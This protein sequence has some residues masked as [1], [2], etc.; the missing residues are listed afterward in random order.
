MY[1]LLFTCLSVRAVHIEVVPDMSFLSFFQALIRFSNI[2]GF[3]ES[4]LSDNA[5][6]FLGSG[7]LFKRLQDYQT[8]FGSCKIKWE[9]IPL[10]SPW[11]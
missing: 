6:T 8:K 10:F 2:Y 3:P 5:K 4:I 11:V 9:T 7:K 1:L